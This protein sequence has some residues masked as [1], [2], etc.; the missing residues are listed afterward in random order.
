MKVLPQDRDPKTKQWRKAT[1]RV[2][3]EDGSEREFVLRG[4]QLDPENLEDLHAAMVGGGATVLDS[5]SLDLFGRFEQE[6][7]DDLDAWDYEEE[8]A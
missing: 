4:S 7:E 1:I 3:L 2:T 6:S 5:P 8:A